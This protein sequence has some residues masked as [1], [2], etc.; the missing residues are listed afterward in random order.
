MSNTD[1]SSSRQ[2]PFIFCWGSSGLPATSALAFAHVRQGFQDWPAHSLELVPLSSPTPA[3]H[4]LKFSTSVDSG[5]HAAQLKALSLKFRAWPHRPHGSLGCLSAWSSHFRLT[6]PGI[7][8]PR[9]RTLVG[10]NPTL[11][12][13]HGKLTPETIAREAYCF[14]YLGT[15]PSFWKR[16]EEG[17][18][19]T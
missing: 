10:Q 9:P 15:N 7:P 8:C 2:L 1:L 14:P 6:V 11:H 18:R 4:T 16:T 17:R 12:H 13:P 5:F 19:W 3:P